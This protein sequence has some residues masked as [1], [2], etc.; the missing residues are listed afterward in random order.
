MQSLADRDTKATKYNWLTDI[1]KVEGQLAN[2]FSPS[3]F[4]L[5]LCRVLH[6][7]NKLAFLAIFFTAI[8]TLY[9]A[10][11]KASTICLF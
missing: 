11:L 3:S 9:S 4:I 8:V 10:T 1:I 7:L 5:N 2:G 6:L